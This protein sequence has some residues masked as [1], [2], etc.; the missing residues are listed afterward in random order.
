MKVAVV[1]ATGMVGEVML[2]VLA[3]RR[4]PVTELLP[5]ASERSVGKEVIFQGKPHKV[6]GLAD[7]VAA[8]PAIA[9]F[10]A[11]G[12]ISLEWAPKFAAAGTTVIDNSSAWRMDPDKKLVVP[13]INASQITRE[14][15]IIANPNCSTIQMVMAL[16]P[17]HK[18]YTINR[19]VVSTYQSITGTGVKAVRQLENEYAGQQGEMAYPYPIHRNALPHCDVFEENGYTKEEM[20]LVRETQKILDDNTIA[21]TSTAIRI[22]VVGGHS[23]SVNLQFENDFDVNDIRKLLNETPGVTVQDNTDTNTYPMPIYAQGKD[24]VFVGRI[25]RDHSQPNSLNLWIVADNLRKGAATNTVQIAE[26]LAANQLAG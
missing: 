24:D 15:K 16:A 7:A 2:Q 10:S 23:E 13:E 6:I 4:F 8:K 14:D 22:P 3:E 18:K 9:L 12:A 19:V 5:V 20:K 1:G 26:Y 21:V 11:G 17:L 25:R